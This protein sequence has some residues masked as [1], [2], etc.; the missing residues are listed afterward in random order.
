MLNDVSNIS[1]Q[2]PSKSFEIRD[3]QVKKVEE[4]LLQLKRR[5]YAYRYLEKEETQANQNMLV[6]F[7]EAEAIFLNSLNGNRHLLETQKIVEN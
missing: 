7:H 6:W 1:N 4:L 3:I 2:L 5:V